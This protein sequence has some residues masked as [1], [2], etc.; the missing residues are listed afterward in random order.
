MHDMNRIKK[1]LVDKSREG[2][3]YDSVLNS[4]INNEKNPVLAKD[5]ADVKRMFEEAVLV[6]PNFKFVQAMLNLQYIKDANTG[7]YYLVDPIEKKIESI[8]ESVVRTAFSTKAFDRLQA[9]RLYSARLGYNPN[10]TDFLYQEGHIYSINLYRPAD[11]QVP[12][13]TKGLKVPETKL[14]AIYDEYLKNLTRNQLSY[15]Y[16]MAFLAATVQSGFKPQN[17]CVLIG[18]PGLGKGVYY[19][20]LSEL[21]GNNNAATSMASKLADSNFNGWAKNKKVLFFDEL[22]IRKPEDE[23]ALKPYVGPEIEIEE[24]GVDKRTYTNY[25]SIMIATNDIGDLKL[26][27]GDRRFCMVDTGDKTLQS[28]VVKFYVM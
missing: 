15:D 9:E 20:I 13:F 25:A 18:I 21:V 19:Q 7:N 17:Y 5:L 12:Y 26:Q 1:Y 3:D 22:K 27:E 14:P 8:E 24:K 16:C 6:Y 11:W 23:D 2:L 10:S 4:Y 28:M